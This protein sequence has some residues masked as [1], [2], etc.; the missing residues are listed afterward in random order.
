MNPE[1]TRM[2]VLLSPGW[3]FEFETFKA[4]GEAPRT[5]RGGASEQMLSRGNASA[6]LEFAQKSFI[7]RLVHM[8]QER[9]FHAGAAATRGAAYCA[10]SSSKAFACF[11]SSVS[12]PSVNQL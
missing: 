7:G 1:P 6:E 3:K 4:P 12:N 2:V 11:K 9:K 10:S 5:A 8:C